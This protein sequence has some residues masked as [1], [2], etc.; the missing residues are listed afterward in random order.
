[1]NNS[2]FWRPRKE[3]SGVMKIEYQQGSGR[4]LQRGN[5]K[6]TIQLQS[7]LPRPKPIQKYRGKTKNSLDKERNERPYVV[8]YVLQ[9][10]S[11]REI[12]EGV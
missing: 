1:M 9:K 4:L 6:R 11:Q 2:Q 7:D 12:L 10:A 3:K 5:S 8:L